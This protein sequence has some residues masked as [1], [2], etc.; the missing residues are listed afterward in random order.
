MPSD[1]RDL[2]NRFESCNVLVIGESML[3]VYMRGTA[4]RVCREAPVPIVAISQVDEAPGGAANVA[5]NLAALGSHVTFVSALGADAEGTT[6]VRLLET[7]GVDTEAVSTE[8]TR[9]TLTKQRIV[10]GSQMLVRF[11]QGTTAPVCSRIEAS[12]VRALE[13]AWSVADAVVISDYGYGVLTHD[14]IAAMTRLQ[15][16]SHRPVLIDAK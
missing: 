11:D 13:A 15:A 9:R 1:W 12:L 8:A 3:D 10:A 7:L 4:D 2:V 16:Q 6:L 14:V 5:A